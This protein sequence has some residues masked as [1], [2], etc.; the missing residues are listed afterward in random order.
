MSLSVGIVGLPNV[1]KSTTFNALTKAQNAQSANYP[2]CTIEPNKAMVEVPDIRLNKLAEIVNPERIMHSLI[3]FVDIAGL[4]KGASKGEGLGNKFLSNIRETEMILHIV[5]C[6]DEENITH[7]EG[8]VDPIRDIEII[9][10]E[11]IL[12]DIE[13]LNKKIEKLTKEVKSNQKGA[14]EN[15]E[16][17]NLLLEHLNKGLPA[18]SYLDK[19]NEVYKNL[20]KELRLLSAKEVIYGAN[21]DEEGIN[22]DNQYVKNL[23]EYAKKN[24]HEVIKL[25]AKIEE[26]L[27]GISDEES[28]EL[29]NS[30]GVKESGL[31]Q[32]IRTA[33]S[34]LGLISYF[35][36][37]TIE[38]R[39]WTIK[40]GW[41]APK[42]ASVI[43]NDFEKGFIKAEVISYQDY[44][45]YGG[46]TKVKEAGKLRLEGKDYIVND[47]DIMHFRFN[48]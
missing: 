15:L 31:D 16:L 19:E 14:K 8:K 27:V 1:G 18:S 23:K 25:C 44:I 39:S 3:E 7:V 41:K 48:V 34:K 35:T 13:Q 2:F 11:L 43:H 10:T 24:N 17:A 42:A 20:I 45:E 6:F 29:L 28:Y 4:V 36:A 30:L 32:I 40:K 33:F 38:V 46:E 22:E 47:G 9:N 12:A 21:V 37:G 26:E 5:R